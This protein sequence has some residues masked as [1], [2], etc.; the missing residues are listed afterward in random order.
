MLTD[1]G[2]LQFG[3]A[4]TRGAIHTYPGYDELSGILVVGVNPLPQQWDEAYQVKLVA[5]CH[6]VLQSPSRGCQATTPRPCSH[7]HPAFFE[8]HDRKKDDEQLMQ[9]SVGWEATGEG[10]TRFAQEM[11]QQF[12][13]GRD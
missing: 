4:G 3:E 13:S 1:H 5:L 11:R 8:A 7:P 12:P 9:E 10:I 6:D 2:I